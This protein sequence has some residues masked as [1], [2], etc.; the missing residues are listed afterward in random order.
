[1]RNRSLCRSLSA[2]AGL[3]AIFLAGIPSFGAVVV[4]LDEGGSLRGVNMPRITSPIAALEALASPPAGL[5][6]AV[7]PGTRVVSFLAEQ[8]Y[9]EVDFSQAIL[10]QG[11]DDARIEVIF[12][13]VRKTLESM[14]LTE[15]VRM[16]V[17]GA[18]LYSYLRPVTPVQPRAQAQ[19]EPRPS[20]GA[21]SGK[22]IS[23]SPGHGL[24]WTGSSWVYD[25]P[26]TCGLAREDD[27]NVEITRYLDIYLRQDGATTINYRC[28]D[29]NAGIYPTANTPWWQMGGSY[30]LQ[31]IGY[32]C[33]VYACDSGDCSLGVGGDESTDNI[34]CRP[35]ASDY[36]NTDIHVA[37]HTNALS[38][39][40]Y[41]TACPN[42]T[43]TFYDNS[44]E[45]A[46][47]G[48]VSRT[49]A[50]NIQ[51]Q[52]INV[53]RTKYSDASWSDRGAKDANGAYAETRIPDRPC[54]LVELAFHD[55]C[56]RDAAY[57]K[58]NCFRSMVTWAIYKGI[59]SYFGVTPTWD[60]Y[61]YEI[62]SDDIPEVMDRFETRD[63][64]I[65]LHNRGCLWNEAQRFRLGAVGDSDPFTTQTRV[66]IPTEAEPDQ[67]YTFTIRFK[68]PGQVGTYRTDW[69]MLREYTTWFGPTVAKDVQ[70][71]DL[72]P[73]EEP[74]TTPTGLCATVIDIN[75]IDL[76][77]SSST[78]NIGVVGYKVYRN[79]VLLAT[80]TATSYSDTTA[81][82][83][84]VY[85]YQV[86]AYDL[87]ENE[88]PKCGAVVVGT[89]LV[90]DF[91]I[92]NPAATF[93][94]TWSTGTAAPDK[95][96]DNY[97]YGSCAISVGRVAR[98][99]PDIDVPGIY[100][101]QIW[102]P[103]ASNYS[104][105]APFTV[106]YDGGSALVQ[107]DQTTGG[108]AW[109]EIGQFA[110]A[111]GKSG[112]LQLTNATGEPSTTYVVA[113]AARFQLLIP[114]DT[115][116]P[117]INSVFVSP[118]MA[119]AGYPVN[120]S[121]SVTDNVAVTDVK[122]NGT[123]LV[124][125]AID[126]WGGTLIADSGLGQHTVNIVARDSAGN[127][128]T[129]TSAG[130]TTAPV[131]GLSNSALLLAG[132]AQE[133]ACR[134]LFKTWGY[135]SVLDAD[136]FEVSD[137]SGTPVKVHCPGHGLSAMKFVIVFGIANFAQTPLCLESQP[138]QM[139]VIY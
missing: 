119:A 41:G 58:D 118:A 120:V 59:C 52:L 43:E 21:L 13:Q 134:Y 108:G 79:G 86:S 103:Q 67:D 60:I 35:V 104:R 133:G 139:Q 33:S 15:S 105:M 112:Y 54:V 94:G 37:M 97:R 44:A 20:V 56:D 88:S 76:S 110:F 40:C 5:S 27:H 138:A 6:S 121:V 16:T 42:G 18:P 131:F 90:T 123:P 10:A 14:G 29:K 25:R 106:V 24:H 115:T 64:H 72:T 49:L 8:D 39:D 17:N 122:A 19:T 73:D 62:V 53:I 116:P 126:T 12:D 130:Y 87:H 66:T 84:S 95:Y 82:S 85:A 55:S 50:Q 100:S 101:V 36:D 81:T 65:T 89:S 71:L 9:T 4:Y 28:L 1:M 127:E 46:A 77:W 113:D 70:V 92:D 109:R 32:P 11:M 26:V 68:A 83:G 69:R 99:V 34:R 114:T 61:S 91:I 30:W 117:A 124:L 3:A 125:T 22:R 107:V 111:V 31:H 102:Y 129:D 80:T 47:Y 57:L 63:V 93:A 7:P 38:G 136:N 132:A 128:S 2:V 137:G 23:L 51:S 45:H 96:G 78:D 135:A 48:A 75:R 74:P 98:W